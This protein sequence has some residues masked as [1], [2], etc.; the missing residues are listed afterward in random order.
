MLVLDQFGVSIVMVVVI[1]V[2]HWWDAG[3]VKI[4]VRLTAKDAAQIHEERVEL[5]SFL[6]IGAELKHSMRL[7]M[8]TVNESFAE[9]GE[10]Q[11]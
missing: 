9:A 1:V 8:S 6:F 7:C 3:V 5:S 11:R 10:A 2:E 4:C